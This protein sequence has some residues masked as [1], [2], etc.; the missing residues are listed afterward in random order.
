MEIRRAIAMGIIK[1]KVSQHDG[2]RGINKFADMFNRVASTRLRE[3]EK[4]TE[5][6]RIINE[7]KG[8]ILDH[9]LKE[10][11][12]NNEEPII[13]KNEIFLDRL[14]KNQR[15]DFD[16]FFTKLDGKMDQM[17]SEIADIKATVDAQQV[18]VDK[19]AQP[20]NRN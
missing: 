3:T 4:L 10:Q 12:F 20:G 5:M 19:L 15:R 1:P 2:G 6:L 11:D 7:Q 16:L 9:V 8:R 17:R 13:E 18:K 14:V